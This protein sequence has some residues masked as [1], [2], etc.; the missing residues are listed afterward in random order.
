MGLLFLI[1]L[2]DRITSFL[3]TSGCHHVNLQ[4]YQVSGLFPTYIMLLLLLPKLNQRALVGSR[5]LGSEGFSP[6]SLREVGVVTV[7]RQKAGG[8]R[9]EGRASQETKHGRKV[10][11]GDVRKTAFTFPSCECCCIAPKAFP[12]TTTCY[13]RETGPWG[14]RPGRFRALLR[15][16]SGPESRLEAP[17]T[18][19]VAALG[20]RWDTKD[21]HA[22]GP[23]GRKRP[24]CKLTLPCACLCPAP[25]HAERGRGT[26]GPGERAGWETVRGPRRRRRADSLLT[27][28]ECVS[29][30][31]ET[32]KRGIG[33]RTPARALF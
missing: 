30:P 29:A 25:G 23:R 18:R 2:L 4:P 19:S 27:L 32:E 26:R 33:T 11:K 7:R 16:L 24:Q 12:L 31:C 10:L 5:G 1:Y 15:E 17:G 22:V 13:K 20:V 8:R 6:S 9:R 14:S 28:Q 21:A 3:G